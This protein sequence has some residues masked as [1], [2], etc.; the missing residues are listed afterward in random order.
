MFS[1]VLQSANR[2]YNVFL[3]N[4]TVYILHTLC[5][6]EYYWGQNLISEKSHI[7]YNTYCIV[8]IMYNIIYNILF[9]VIVTAFAVSTPSVYC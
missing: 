8:Y 2:Q 9:E 1:T 6:T 4:L 7:I 5:F 3:P